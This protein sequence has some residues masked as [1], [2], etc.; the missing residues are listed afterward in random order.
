M[1][2]VLKRAG[3]TV[4]VSG[5]AGSVKP[6]VKGLE[7]VLSLGKEFNDEPQAESETLQQ[8]RNET[9]TPTSNPI[10][11]QAASST[12]FTRV[13]RRASHTYEDGDPSK[14]LEIMTMS[15]VVDRFAG[16]GRRRSSGKIPGKL[17]KERAGGSTNGNNDDG[18]WGKVKNA[19][20]MGGPGS[21]GGGRRKSSVKEF[22]GEWLRKMR[23]NNTGSE[24]R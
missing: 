8:S 12:G 6:S 7:D 19:V 5:E 15:N 16:I 20:N 24:E 22:G 4:A 3:S 13:A 18:G 9:A 14:N 17:V 10:M 1:L 21:L 23:V 2:T 11:S